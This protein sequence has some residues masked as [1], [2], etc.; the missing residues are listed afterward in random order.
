MEMKK[1]LVLAFAALASATAAAQQI[2]EVAPGMHSGDSLTVLV[3]SLRRELQA[4]KASGEELEADARNRRIW[5]DRA[6]YFNVAYVTQSLTQKDISG[7]WRADYGVA[8]TSGRT[9]YLHKKP[10]WGMVK[11]GLDWSYLDINFA[12]YVD[13]WGFFSGEGSGG[14]IAGDGGNY[15]DPGDYGTPGSTDGYEG[16]TED[17]YQAEV[18]ISIGPSVTVNPVDELKAALYFRVTPSFSM[19]YAADELSTSYGTFFSFGGS[20]AWKAISLGIEGRWGNVKY[21]S[22]LDMGAL[23]DIED[24]DDISLAGDLEKAKW[25]VGSMRFY[26]SLR[27]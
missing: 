12:K 17:M 14:D 11:F 2:P 25:K 23:D 26:V 15:Y 8:L 3:D 4:V 7:T 21:G 24:E 19:L 22:V 10:L 18:G 5:N 13:K 27:F 1:T 6:K 20:V 9:Y 16:E